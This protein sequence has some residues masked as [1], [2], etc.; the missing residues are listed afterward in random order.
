MRVKKNSKA[1]AGSEIVVGGGKSL[2]NARAKSIGILVI[3]FILL[4]L[5]A[6]VGSKYF[7]HK[8]ATN[9]AQKANHVVADQARSLSESGKYKEAEDYIATQIKVAKSGADKASWY[10][11]ASNTAINNK[12]YND[13]LTYA[14]KAYEEFPSSETAYAVAQAYEKLNDKDNARKNLQ[15]AIDKLD[16]SA[17]SYQIKLKQYQQEMAGLQ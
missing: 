15:I 10:I 4:G 13:A 9:N 16:K 14:N 8:K 12:Q 3:A 11:Q 5:L 17:T 1:D 2:I 7:S 6:V